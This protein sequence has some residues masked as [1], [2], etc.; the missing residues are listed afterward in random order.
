MG[1]VSKQSIQGTIATYFGVAIG[2]VTNFFVITKYLSTEQ[3]GLLNNLL[4]NTAIF[5]SSLAQ[6]GISSSAVRFFPYFHN[7]DNKNNGLFFWT[8]A[9]PFVGYVLFAVLFIALKD[10]VIPFF[11]QN[12]PL[13]TNYY[14]A[15]LPLAFCMIYL[16]VFETNA[17]VLMKIVVPRFVRE[18]VIRLIMLGFY[19]LFAF[20]FLTF[21]GLVKGQCLT[22]AIAMF[23][24][25]AYLIYLNKISIK[26]NFAF[27]RKNKHLLKSICLYSAFLFITAITINFTPFLTSLFLTAKIGESF[28]GIYTIAI[29][30][31]A[32]VVIPCRSLIPILA[33]KISTYIKEN[34][35]NKV[36]S[37]LKKCTGSAFLVGCFIHLAIWTNIDLIYHLLPNGSTYSIAKYAF[38]VLSLTNIVHAT[39]TI[40]NSTLNF[41]K[42]YVFA[43]FFTIFHTALTVILSNFLIAKFDIVGAALS[44][45]ITYSIFYLF[46]FGILRIFTHFTPFSLSMVK[47]LALLICLNLINDIIVSSFPDFNVWLSSI[48]RSLLI[49]GVFAACAYKLCLSKDINDIVDNYFT[50]IK[51]FFLT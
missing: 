49:L 9:I 38:F 33:P 40:L 7:E 43:L 17:N 31:S 47:T 1:I 22:Y 11:G 46:V 36:S 12:A 27:L 16:S 21:D 20:N 3:V 26:P 19:I 23:I 8:V 44:N 13:F 4:V 48:I 6:L 42:Y 51:G 35:W 50:R 34:D 45:L 24:N 25:L 29:F 41:S 15:V 5:F 18:V 30:M 2:F 14:V 39:F 28:T 32:L 37:T 10:V